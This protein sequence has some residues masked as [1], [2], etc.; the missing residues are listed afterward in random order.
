MINRFIL[1][2]TSYFGPG[3]RR[4]LPAA[5]ARLGKSKA[6]VV[7][8]PGL[9]KFGVA[10]MVTDVLDEGG[11][12]YEIF[13]DVKPNPTVANVQHGVEAFR[14]SGADIIIA[15]GGGSAIDT[16]KGIG[17]VINNP[18]FADVVSLE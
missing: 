15:I 16:A 10:K 12:A 9:I 14:K 3:A 7:T 6:L 17:I 11:V 18:E 4:E 5:V 8:D 1:N 13:S 2:E